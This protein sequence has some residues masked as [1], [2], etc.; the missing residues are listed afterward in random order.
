MLK[1]MS[2]RL[3]RVNSPAYVFVLGWLYGV[4]GFLSPNLM[5]YKQ[6]SVVFFSFLRF[7]IR[8]QTAFGVA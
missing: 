8:I 5:P 1:L 6:E 4:F 2:S 3:K 7:E